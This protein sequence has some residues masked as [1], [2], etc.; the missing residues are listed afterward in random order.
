MIGGRFLSGGNPGDVFF[1]CVLLASIW[2][3]LQGFGR[4]R[5]K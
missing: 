4:F 2:L 5:E 3:A 1:V